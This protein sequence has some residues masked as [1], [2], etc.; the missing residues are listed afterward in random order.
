MCA[1]CMYTYVI[2]VNVN[3]YESIHIAGNLARIK[4]LSVGVGGI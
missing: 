4:W 2:V 3:E 1:L